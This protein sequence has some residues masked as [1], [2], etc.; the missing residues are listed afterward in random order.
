MGKLFFFYTYLTMVSLNIQLVLQRESDLD[1][2]WIGLK[3]LL[4]LVN[5][6][7]L[8]KSPIQK[9]ITGCHPT[10]TISDQL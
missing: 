4:A 1:L 9:L 7:W 8:A 2:L 5:S 6:S 10:R 3:G